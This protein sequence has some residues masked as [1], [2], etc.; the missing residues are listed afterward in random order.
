MR[1]SGP[2]APVTSTPWRIS[3]FRAVAAAVAALLG[4]TGIGCG[5]DGQPTSPAVRVSP[6][7]RY[8]APTGT[9]D[10]DGS[11]RRPWDLATALS[12]PLGLSPGDTLWLRGGRYHG[13]FTSQLTGT[14][15]ARIVVRQYPGERAILDNAGCSDPAL[16]VH[17]AYTDYRDF[18]V[19]NSAPRAGGPQGIDAFGDGIRFINLVVH[20]AAGSGVGFWKEAEGGEIY[21]CILYNNGRTLNLDHGIY[22][23]NATG[24]KHIADNVIFDSWAFGVHVHGSENGPVA[25]Y[26]IEGNAIFGNGSIGENDAAP[27]LLVGGGRPASRIVVRDNYLYGPPDGSGNM[28]LGYDVPNADLVLTNNVIV[29]GDPALRLWYWSSVSA[30]GNVTAA[31]FTQVDVRGNAR[32]IDWRGAAFHADAAAPD[33]TLN[34]DHLTLSQ[35]LVQTGF[36]GTAT[37]L[38]AP[39]SPWI[40]VRPNAYETG[41]GHVIIYGWGK[42]SQVAVDLSAIL[43]VGDPYE[44]RPVERLFDPPVLAG[45][46]AGGTLSL[47]MTPLRPPAP[48]DAGA[49]APS[50]RP[51][52]GVFL[53]TRPVSP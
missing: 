34:D 16:T 46:Y 21:G 31:A 52:L 38:A 35:W 9:G 28:W 42:E 39:S 11:D 7:E 4:A 6:V 49:S 22:T 13:C 29:G 33:W 40:F 23:Q 20:D 48:I 43:R 44:V 5:R 36:G 47:P 15:G 37:V 53:V 3:G 8:A 51:A 10:G 14:A 24:T 25:G 19:T 50:T 45:V 26:T 27:N 17:G 18:E 12:D 32:G 2:Y 41:R 1:T 30:S